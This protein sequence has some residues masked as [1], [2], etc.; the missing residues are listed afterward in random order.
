M[1]SPSMYIYIKKNFHW[2]PLID[3]LIPSHCTFEVKAIQTF[4]LITMSAIWTTRKYI[5][6]DVGGYK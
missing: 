1:L 4:R 6:A 2:I 5:A 3:H